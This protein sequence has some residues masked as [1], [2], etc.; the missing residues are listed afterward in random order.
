MGKG[1]DGEEL[2]TKSSKQETVSTP[3]IQNFKQSLALKT[4]V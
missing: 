4:S 1:L 3:L 2:L